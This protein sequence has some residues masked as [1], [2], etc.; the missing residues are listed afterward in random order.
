MPAWEDRLS[1]EEIWKTILFL[2]EAAGV[3][4]RRWEAKLEPR[5]LASSPSAESLSRTQPPTPNTQHP[6][7][8]SEAWAQQADVG[9]GK[10]VYEKRCA[11]CHGFEGR[12]DGVAAPFLEPRPR[13]FTL[14][15]Y[16]I[17]STPSGTLPTDDDL[18]TIVAGGMPG[19]S[20]PGWNTLPERDRWAVIQYLKSFSD[21][22][23]GE[24][25][26]QP[27]KVGNEVASSKESLDKGRQLYQDLECFTCHGKEGRADGASAPTLKDDWGHRIRPADL[28]KRWTFRGGGSVR[29]IF[30][31]FNTGIAGTPMPSYA[32]SIDAEQSWHLSNYVASLGPESPNY[33]TVMA[34]RLMRR[35]MPAAPT[36][37]LWEQIPAVNLPLV[38]QVIVDPRNVSPGIYMVSVKSI[39]Y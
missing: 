1:E 6:P 19:T 35:D 3:Q 25:Q 39:Y 27:I 17:R 37:P 14:G 8:S 36:D 13:D 23:K 15:L 28:T 22:F 11:F 7:F 32:D 38:V 12:G 26:G 31:R 16:K 24:G 33:G 20:M 2:Y 4:P 18:F 29:A 21:R 9:L 10:E 30:T 34:A 5:L